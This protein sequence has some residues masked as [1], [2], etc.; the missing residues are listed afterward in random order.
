MAFSLGWRLYVTR[1]GWVSRGRQL[2]HCSWSLRTT[3]R[4]ACIANWTKQPQPT[5]LVKKFW[6]RWTGRQHSSIFNFGWEF[7]GEQSSSFS[8]HGG[9]NIKSTRTPRKFFK[10]QNKNWDEKKQLLKHL[11]FMSKK[12]KNKNAQC[13]MDIFFRV[14]SSCGL[15]MQLYK[16][17]Q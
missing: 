7:E 9:W 8:L 1:L 14:H 3:R 6:W 2:R 17:E 10:V 4:K 11:M 5:D 12:K 16:D 13:S 15:R